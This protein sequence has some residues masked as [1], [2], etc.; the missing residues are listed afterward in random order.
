MPI[1]AAAGLRSGGFENADGGGSD[2]RADAIA[3]N[4]R[5]LVCA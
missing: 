5:D 2:F 3:G 4:K 1:E